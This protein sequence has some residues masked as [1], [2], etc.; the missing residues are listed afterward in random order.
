MSSYMPHGY[1]LLWQPPL[2]ALH[3]ISD[4]LIGIAYFSIPLMLWYFIRKR[5]ATP[6]RGLFVLFA[7]FIY[8]CGMTHVM[9]VVTL[10]FP[11]YWL[12]GLIKAGTAAISVTTALV[13][14]PA[15]PRML[16]LRSPQELEILNQELQATLAEKDRLLIAYQREQHIAATLQ[17]ALLP[18]QIPHIAGLRIDTAYVPA[19]SETEIGGDWYDAFGLSERIVAFTV[20]DVAGHGLRAASAMGTVRQALRTAAREHVDPTRVFATVNALVCAEAFDLVTAFYGV[21][22]LETGV[23]RYGNAGHPPPLVVRTHDRIETLETGGLILGVNRSSEYD[24]HETQLHLGEALVLY[25]DGVVEV[26]R[27]FIDGTGKLEDAARIEAAD[28]HGNIAESVLARV[29]AETQPRDD[30]AVMIVGVTDIGAEPVV[31]E[32]KHWAFDAH[33]VNEA[34]RIQRALMWYLGETASRESDFAS[35]E[36][37]FSE[38]IGNVARHTDGHARVSI[39]WKNASAVLTVRDRGGSFLPKLELPDPM[40]EGGRGLFL[41]H[42]LAQDVRIDRSDDGNVVSVTLPATSA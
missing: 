18:Q 21:L 3:V 8:W 24:T 10:W 12:D 9:S 16:A 36:V 42:A 4:V 28:P 2:V 17:R 39:E 32:T 25:T 35:C 26:Q 20:G 1:C 22:D 41:V 37:I 34:R 15:I 31:R 7:A 11:F 13:L 33:N 40:D 30:C 23:L 6:F 38:L 19:S 5:A 14:F 29:L 27:R